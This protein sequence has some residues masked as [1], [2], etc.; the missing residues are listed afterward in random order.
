M[1]DLELVHYLIMAGAGSDLSGVS[2]YLSLTTY[3]AL[4]LRHGML[5]NRLGLLVTVVVPYYYLKTRGMATS[6]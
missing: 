2:R 4:S 3:V 5:E 1:I 6:V